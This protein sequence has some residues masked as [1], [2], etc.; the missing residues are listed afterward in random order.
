MPRPGEISLAHHGVLFLDEVPEF[1][2][3]ALEALRQPLEDRRVTIVRARCAATY[4][5]AFALCAAMTP[6]PCGYRGSPMR[7]CT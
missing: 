4:P 7:A 3:P 1:Q 5:A 6:C 2:R